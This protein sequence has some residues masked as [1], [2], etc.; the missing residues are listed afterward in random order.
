V[1]T[2]KG[3]ICKEKKERLVALTKKKREKEIQ[4]LDREIARLMKEKAKVFECTS[5]KTE[6]QKEVAPLV[7][8]IKKREERR[9][10]LLYKLNNERVCGEAQIFMKAGDKEI[11]FINVLVMENSVECPYK[12]VLVVG[13]NTALGEAIRRTPTG[14]VGVY[15]NGKARTEIR[16]D[17]KIF[18]EEE[19]DEEEVAN[20]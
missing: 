3:I 20:V 14:S 17:Q 4:E 13:K 16:V 19:E 1:T 7:E 10:G 18:F 2:E 5:S 6:A 12:S 9:K 8:K 15:Q 11:G